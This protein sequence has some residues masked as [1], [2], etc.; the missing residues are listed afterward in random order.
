M[1][2]NKLKWLLDLL[3][4]LMLFTFFNT[5]ILGGLTYHEIAGLVF[6]GVF[7]THIVLNIDWVKKVTLKLFDRR[8]PW[9][10][11]VSYMLNVLL[12]VSMSFVIFSGLA[13]SRIV[14]PQFRLGNES[15]FRSAHIASSSLIL[16]LVGV[17]LGIH[18]HWV[19]SVFQKMLAY[20]SKAAW[21]RYV[22]PAVAGLILLLGVYEIQ[23]TSFISRAAGVFSLFGGNGA[24]GGFSGHFQQGGAAGQ[25][26]FSGGAPSGSFGGDH[27]FAGSGGARHAFNGDGFHHG[28]QGGN[29]NVVTVLATYAAITGAF[30]IVAYYS[31]KLTLWRR[32]KSL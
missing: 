10:T 9:R 17:H 14:L 21:T 28:A 4:G 30:A 20:R 2:K 16:I 26:H 25:G 32:R 13:I 1:K 11:R 22:L 6:A 3:M 24:Q 8:L 7:L 5:G 19:M 18:W 31:R 12:L 15:W 29:A 23:Q 27:H